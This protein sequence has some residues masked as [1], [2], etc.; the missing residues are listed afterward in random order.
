M[1][2]E[3][4][5]Y[6]NRRRPLNFRRILFFY[7]ILS[8]HQIIKIRCSLRSFLCEEAKIKQR[9]S[10]KKE[11]CEIG[12][13]AIWEFRFTSFF[14][15][16]QLIYIYFYIRNK[17]TFEEYSVKFSLIIMKKWAIDSE[18]LQTSQKKVSLR[19]TAVN[20]SLDHQKSKNLKHFISL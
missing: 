18:S 12:E 5:F 10:L 20:S 3:T 13:E 15:T 1:I 4:K 19:W 16:T 9:T 6:K 14:F 11:L 2:F 7:F 17:V 8:W